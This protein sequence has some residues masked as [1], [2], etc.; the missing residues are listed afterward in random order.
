[1]GPLTSS[2]RRFMSFFGFWF[3]AVAIA[4]GLGLIY[5]LAVIMIPSLRVSII[6]ARSLYQ[7]DRKMVEDILSCPTHSWVDQVGDYWVIHLLS[8]NLSPVAM[9]ELIEELKPIMN[10]DPSY[11]NYPTLDDYEKESPM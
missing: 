1:M 2:M 9:K 5:R 3:I 7:V 11:G 4:T 6:M 8:K 10:P